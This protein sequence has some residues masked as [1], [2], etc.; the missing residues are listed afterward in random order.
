VTVVPHQNSE[1]QPFRVQER[2]EGGFR[3]VPAGSPRAGKKEREA[4]FSDVRKSGASPEGYGERMLCHTYPGT[5]GGKEGGKKEKY[6]FPSPARSPVQRS[7]EEG[8]RGPTVSPFLADEK[9]RRKERGGETSSSFPPPR[10]VGRRSSRPGTN[11][12]KNGT[13]LTSPLRL[14]KKKKKGGERRAGVLSCVWIKS[15]F[16]RP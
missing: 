2:G 1:E 16:C 7:R 10:W 6:R 5:R 13:R 3:V 8:K 14:G 15:S 11:S 12:R 4:D 9:R